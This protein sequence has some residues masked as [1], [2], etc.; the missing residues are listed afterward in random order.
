MAVDVWVVFEAEHVVG[1]REVDPAEGDPQR[2][3][4]CEARPAAEHA[5][6]PPL[7]QPRHRPGHRLAIELQ[8]RARVLGQE[9]GRHEPD[10]VARVVDVDV[11][12]R[13][14]RALDARLVRLVL[15]GVVVEAVGLRRV[16]VAMLSSSSGAIDIG[17]PSSGMG[18]SS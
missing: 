12:E 15:G 7:D 17:T 8:R 13:A 1:E 3:E 6:R 14:D 9:L 2:R 10:V 4:E 11:A 16:A 18:A 5:A